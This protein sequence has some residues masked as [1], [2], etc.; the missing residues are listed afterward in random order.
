M[1]N[2]I[3]IR[4]SD[5][6]RTTL[7]LL[8]FLGL[9][10]ALLGFILSPIA[11]ARNRDVYPS[12][13]EA[14]ALQFFREHQADFERLRNLVAA[15]PSLIYLH[16]ERGEVAPK[17]TFGNDTGALNEVLTLMTRL[18]LVS[19]NG[20][21]SGWGLRMSFWSEGM[22]MAS[23]TRSFWFSD[24]PPSPDRVFAT[25]GDHFPDKSGSGSA[26]CTITPHWYLRFDW[27]G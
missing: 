6:G 14:P 24:I 5:S 7:T 17:D 25:F 22:V 1:N 16:R 8:V 18:Q 2:I 4:R 27:G 12:K 26:Y 20:A 13:E 23:V 10:L 19:V 21:A 9:G 11:P 3:A 15:H